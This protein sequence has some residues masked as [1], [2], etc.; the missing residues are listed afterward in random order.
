MGTRPRRAHAIAALLVVLG[1]A[2]I[3]VYVDFAQDAA[4]YTA[5]L[6]KKPDNPLP[7]M[8]DLE[9]WNYADRL[10]P[11]LRSAWPSPPTSPPRSAAAAAWWSGCSAAS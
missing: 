4:N 10:R 6:G 9:K 2:W 3:A 11:D 7:W 5:G 1:I 8:A